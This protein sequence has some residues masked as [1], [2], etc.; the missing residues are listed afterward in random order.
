MQNVELTNAKGF[1]A[2]AMFTS[3]GSLQILKFLF[4]IGATKK[5]ISSE[6]GLKLNYCV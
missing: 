4:D 3:F 6:T 1:A 5:S 2:G